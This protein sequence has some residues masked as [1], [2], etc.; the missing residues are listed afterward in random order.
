MS[1]ESTRLPQ[2]LPG[3]N[4]ILD[5]IIALSVLF[6]Y[7]S[8]LTVFSPGSLVFPSHQTFDLIS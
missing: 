1:G 2:M 5:P 4:S 3:F 7:N 6:L 8:A